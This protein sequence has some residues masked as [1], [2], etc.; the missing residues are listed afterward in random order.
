ME[1]DIESY[2]NRWIPFIVFIVCCIFAD[3]RLNTKKLE[4]IE[5]SID[6]LND[7][8]RDLEKEI[9]STNSKLNDLKYKN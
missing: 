7:R 3:V 9:D 4:W 2:I 1:F 8:I 5:K 6:S